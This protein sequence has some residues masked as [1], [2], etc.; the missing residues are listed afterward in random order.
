MTFQYLVS[1][2][3]NYLHKIY[4]TPKEQYIEIVEEVINHAI[5]KYQEMVIYSEWTIQLQKRREK[6]QNVLVLHC[7]KESAE[8]YLSALIFLT[9]GWAL[10][11]Q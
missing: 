6:Q 5:T 9:N 7:W 8:Q 11:K 4:Q 1:Y 3:T 10:V 2:W